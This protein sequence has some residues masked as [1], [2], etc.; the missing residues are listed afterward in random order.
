MNWFRQRLL[1][2]G[3]TDAL[4]L[5]RIGLALIIWTRFGTQLAPFYRPHPENWMLGA[6]FFPASALMLVGWWSRLSTAGT[7]AALWV[8]WLYFAPERGMMDEFEHHHTR[9]IF[10]AT[11]MLA[12]APCG[13]TWS[14]DRWLSVRRAAAQG[15]PAPTGLGPLWAGDLIA[16]QVSSVYLWSAWDKTQWAFLSGERL[17]HMYIRWYLFDYPDWPLFAEACM[18]MA[19][20]TVFIEYLLPFALFVPRFQRV[21]I[22]VGL[23]L[24]AV[25]FVVLPVGTFTCTMMLL[26]LAYVDPWGVRTVVGQLMSP[27]PPPSSS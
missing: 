3:P 19:L 8:G 5:M 13:G 16:L 17:Q 7:A 25:F 27:G 12:M 18:A 2:E 20:F 4:G 9:L 23:M 1:R 22:P 26:Y 6:V 14:L 11:A 21:L 10:A 24:H 15:G